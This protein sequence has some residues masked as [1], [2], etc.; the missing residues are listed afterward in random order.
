MNFDQWWGALTPK[1]Q[2]VLGR[3]NAQYAWGC[4]LDSCVAIL[5]ANAMACENPIYRSLLQ[6]NAK[7]IK[8]ET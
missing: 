2:L 4:A 8:G 3:N 7:E 6:A 5:E 1:E